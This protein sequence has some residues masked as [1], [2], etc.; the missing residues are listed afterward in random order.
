[1]LNKKN[2]IPPEVIVLRF[3][4]EKRKLSILEAGKRSGIKPKHL[5]YMENG[6]RAISKSEIEYLLVAYN[7]TLEIFEEMIDRKIFTKIEANHFF[8]QKEYS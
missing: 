6:K 1:M 3:M 2:N 7:F 8:I 4:R 5:D